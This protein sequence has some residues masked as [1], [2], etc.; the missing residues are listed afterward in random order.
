M[1]IPHRQKSIF[2]LIKEEGANNSVT[3]KDYSLC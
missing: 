2:R 3:Q 1:A